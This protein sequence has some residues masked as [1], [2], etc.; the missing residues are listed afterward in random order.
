[1]KL[2]ILLIIFFF[3]GQR[4]FQYNY[5]ALFVGKLSGLL[6]ILAVPSILKVLILTGKSSQPL[7]A[8]CRYLDTLSHMCDWYEGDICNPN[9]K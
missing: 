3:R 6:S 8:F 4:F 7:S 9:S 1:M 5:F 2:L